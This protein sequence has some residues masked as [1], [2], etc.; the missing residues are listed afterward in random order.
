MKPITKFQLFVLDNLVWLLI[1]LF[2]TYNAIAT[3][4]FF[5]ARNQINILFQSSLMGILV[6]AQGIV[7]MVGELDLSIDATLA[8]APGL[9]ILLATSLT[10][11]NPFLCILLTLAIGAAMGFFN[12][13]CVAKLKTN[14]FLLTLSSQIVMRGLILFMLPFSISGLNSTY[15]FLGRGRIRDMFPVAA[16]SFILI[17]LVFEFIFYKTI[18]GRKFMLTGGNRQASYISGIN[19]DRVIIT[20]FVIA[21]LLAAFAGLIAAGRQNA[22]SNSMGTG[23]VMMAFAG[24]ILGGSSFQGG[25]GKPIGMLGGALLLG[26]IDNSL[27]LRGVNVNLVSATKGLLIFVAIMLDLGKN[28]L[29]TWIMYKENLRKLAGGSNS[30]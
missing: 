18:F 10:E 20:A 3:P 17:F 24:A 26:M 25:R 15:T 11:M 29:N 4:S 2:F 21:G 8:F 6:L 14:S 22:V 19:T 12:G 1:I 23:M 28:K 16:I 13:V 9:T 27:T 5:T 7:M 30:L